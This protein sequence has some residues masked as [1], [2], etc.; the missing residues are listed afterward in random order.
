MAKPAPT[1][2]HRTRKAPVQLGR[3]IAQLRRARGMTQADLGQRVGLSRRMV[4]YYEAQHGNPPAELL[5]KLAKAL[6][7]SLDRLFGL[8]P[9]SAEKQPSSDVRLWRRLRRLESLPPRDREAIFRLIDGFLE[10]RERQAS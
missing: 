6:E 8:K 3:R 1:K 10:S 7:V 4:V 2:Q 9:L 5:P